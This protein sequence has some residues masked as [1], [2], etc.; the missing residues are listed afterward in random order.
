MEFNADCFHIGRD[1]ETAGVCALSSP[2]LREIVINLFV[3]SAD[4]YRCDGNG[5]GNNCLNCLLGCSGDSSFRFFVY[6][7]FE[8]EDGY[9]AEDDNGRE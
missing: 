5:G 7:V 9:G 1:G 2:V 8:H 4:D 3:G 6:H